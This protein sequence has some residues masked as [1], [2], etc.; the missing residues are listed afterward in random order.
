M[1]NSFYD[2]V[3]EAP[4]K[5]KM[6]KCVKGPQYYTTIFF[7]MTNNAN[8]NQINSSKGN[9]GYVEGEMKTASEI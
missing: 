6:K 2:P 3:K 4:N 7:L 8:I 9:K 1:R 5:R